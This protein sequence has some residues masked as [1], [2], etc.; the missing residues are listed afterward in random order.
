M[1]QKI[2]TWSIIR[3][4][5]FTFEFQKC[6]RKEFTIASYFCSRVITSNKKSYNTLSSQDNFN[7]PVIKQIT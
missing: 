7:E 1:S 2:I 4:L 5:S 6:E 3:Y